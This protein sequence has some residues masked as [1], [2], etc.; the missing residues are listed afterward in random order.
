MLIMIHR[1]W[2]PDSIY[3]VKDGLSG[4]IGIGSV[5]SSYKITEHL[6]QY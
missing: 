1:I 3:G 4:Y 5:Q 2:A 6:Q